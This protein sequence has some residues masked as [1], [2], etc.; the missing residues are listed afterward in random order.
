MNGLIR[1]SDKSALESRSSAVSSV[2]GGT[3]LVTLGASALAVAFSGVGV[4]TAASLA[5]GASALGGAGL[6][7]IGAAARH[8]FRY[9]RKLPAA[10]FAATGV[11]GGLVASWPAFVLL[12]WFDVFAAPMWFR[13]IFGGSVL[14]MFFV[15]MTLTLF[16]L[17]SRDAPDI[18]ADAA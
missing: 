15:A 6:V 1:K 7:K 11:L 8:L 4:V 12:R 3:T 14:V 18:P 5:L 16:A 2:L 9:G 10:A 13:Q 17:V